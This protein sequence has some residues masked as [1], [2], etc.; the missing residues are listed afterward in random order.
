MRPL[1]V[2]P[3]AFAGPAASKS[4]PA[5]GRAHASSQ[6][7]R[8]QPARAGCRL[9]DA[10]GSISAIYRNF[11]PTQVAIHPTAGLDQAAQGP[12]L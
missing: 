9:L 12:Q 5:I 7:A 4:A 3:S 2:K 6:S 1:H 11:V 8:D 10:A